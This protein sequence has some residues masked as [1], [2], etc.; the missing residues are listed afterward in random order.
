M[1][2][3]HVSGEPVVRHPSVWYFGVQERG[4]GWGPRF[5]V[6][7]VEGVIAAVGIDE[8][9]WGEYVQCA[10]SFRYSTSLLGF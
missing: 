8:V 1:S 4:L 10:P 2:W 6:I 7:C 3:G 9:T 5:G